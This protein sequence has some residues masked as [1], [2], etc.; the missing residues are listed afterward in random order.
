MTALNIIGDYYKYYDY[1]PLLVIGCMLFLLAS[2][3]LISKVVLRFFSGSKNYLPERNQGGALYENSDVLMQSKADFNG[4]VAPLNSGKKTKSIWIKVCAF[5]LALLLFFT[6]FGDLLQ[7][8]W[9]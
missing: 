6:H 2:S 3:V 5:I 4:F 1:N 7:L 9:Y 8:R